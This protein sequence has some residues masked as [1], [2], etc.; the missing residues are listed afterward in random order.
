[1]FFLRR[2]TFKPALFLLL[3]STLV[4]G[5]C[6]RNSISTSGRYNNGIFVVNEGLFGS[7][8]GALY[9]INRPASFSDSARLTADIYK[10][11]NGVSLGDVV[12]DVEIIQGKA[13][14]V[15][16][17]S[18]KI[19]VAGTDSM[20]AITTI[21]GLQQPRYALALNESKLYVTEWVSFGSPAGNVVIINP[22][23]NT[24]T[25]RVAVGSTPE[26]MAL[27]GNNLYVANS[28]SNTVSVINTLTD[29]VTATITVNAGPRSLCAVTPTSGA[30]QLWVSCYGSLGANFTDGADDVAGSLQRIDP[31]TNTI[32]RTVALAP[33]SLH[34]D[35]MTTNREGTVLYY[36]FTNFSGK[37]HLWQFNAA[38]NATAPSLRIARQFYGLGVDVNGGGIIHCGD[39]YDFITPGKVVRY[40]PNTFAAID[41]FSLESNDPGLSD[42]YGPGG[43]VFTN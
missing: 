17:N 1:M 33:A 40:N 38:S 19:E 27:V 10:L 26:Q 31:V 42:G 25:G 18:N 12:Q 21:T 28:V 30:T 41:S 32:T 4:V 16:N 11:R 7:S 14:I 5:A 2:M 36:L 35:K 13:Y 43:F 9:Y 29:Q 6:R 3:A 34:P 8:N 24:V 22:S 20:N 37:G 23:T 39:A 15:V